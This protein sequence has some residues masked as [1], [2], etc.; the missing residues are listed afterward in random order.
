VRMTTR[1]QA[2]VHTRVDAHIR[3]FIS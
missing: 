2:Q 1:G 3:A